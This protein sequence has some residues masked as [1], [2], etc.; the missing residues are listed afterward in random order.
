MVRGDHIFVYRMGYSHHGIDCGGGRVIHFDSTPWRKLMSVTGW[1]RPCSI[2]EVSLDEFTRGHE[3][4]VR[5]YQSC[6]DPEA[7][8]QRARSRLNEKSYDLLENNCEHFAVWCKTGRPESTQIRAVQRST[9]QLSKAATIAAFGLRLA[10]RLPPTYRPWAWGLAL[11][12]TGGTAASRYWK[13]RRESF[14]RRES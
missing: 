13:C 10:R 9:H 3:F 4:H 11:A 5:P 6:D 14:A 2:R 1:P 7:V 8:I 12:Y